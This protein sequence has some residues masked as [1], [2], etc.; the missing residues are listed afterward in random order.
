MKTQ[1]LSFEGLKEVLR[2]MKLNFGSKATSNQ[3]AE[4]IDRYVL[5][6]N[7]AIFESGNTAI[8][9]TARLGTMILGKK[10]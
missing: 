1:I 2:L 3:H 5:K 7:S 6:M 4:Y 10:E 8:L 9:G